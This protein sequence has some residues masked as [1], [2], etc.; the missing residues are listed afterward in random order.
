MSKKNLNVRS[1]IHN[2][3]K[4]KLKNQKI[5]KVYLEFKNKIKSKPSKVYSVAVSGGPDSL[6]LV[7]LS[8]LY[9][10]KEKVSFNYFLVD[11]KLRQDST[12]EAKKI[13]M[14]LQKYNIKCK[15]LTWNK[16]KKDK[17]I[18]V[19]SSARDAR[20]DLIIKE[21]I[22]KKI[23]YILTAHHSDDL[24]ENFFIRLLRGSGLKGLSS[25]NYLS[26]KIKKNQ[27]IYILRPLLNIP[28]N[29]LI[30]IAKN[31]FN[32]FVND[33]SN[34]NDIF[35]RVKI[36][37]LL[38]KLNHEGLDFNKFKLTLKNLHK[39]NL[40]IDY[41]V[42]ENI[43]KNS[44]ILRDDKKSYILNRLF[45]SQPEE[46]VFRSLS[47][48]LHEIGNK[49]N[50]PRGVKISNLIDKINA[51]KNFKKTSLSG[52]ILEKINNSIVISG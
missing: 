17:K 3:Y 36:R 39:S 7:F 49:K 40:T 48:I 50:Y 1:T 52:C 22:K 4:R 6:A 30:Y 31:T 12:N 42:K 43:K 28:K 23:K 15:I 38:K 19:Q 26:S 16:N 44:R 21:N 47:K 5:K 2:F 34:V 32:F 35:L 41:Y 9:S 29:D 10:L 37:M 8:E 13:K 14:E 33:P 24:Y 18:N 45:F 20:Y 11:H 46:I 25:F 27:N 51:D